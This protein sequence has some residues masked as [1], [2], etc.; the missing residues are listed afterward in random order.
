MTHFHGG[1][2]GVILGIGVEETPSVVID[3][4]SVVV[5]AVPQG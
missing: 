3:D 4:G 5:E 1:G 2:V